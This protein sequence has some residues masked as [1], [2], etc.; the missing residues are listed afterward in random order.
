MVTFTE[1]I[2]NDK[3]NI[4]QM[5]KCVRKTYKKIQQTTQV[6]LRSRKVQPHVM[7]KKIDF[8]NMDNVLENSFRKI[9]LVQEF[10]LNIVPQ[11]IWPTISD[12]ITQKY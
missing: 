1:E 11:K 9:L 10:F 2:L 12:I 7:L 8:E 3:Y 6:E 5:D 4:C